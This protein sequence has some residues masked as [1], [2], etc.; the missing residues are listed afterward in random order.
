MIDRKT[1]ILLKKYLTQY[2]VI[3]ITGP[4][5]S[6]KTTLCKAILSDW[7]YINMEDI[8]TRER[9]KAEPKEFLKEYPE[10][11]IID[12]FQ[13]FPE[14]TSY[15]QVIVDEKAKNGLFVLTGSQNFSSMEYISQSLAGRTAII[16]LLPFSIEEI[17]PLIDNKPLNEIILRGFYPKIYNEDINWTEYY[18]FYVNTYIER[19]VRNLVN[20]K[21]LL[22]FEKFLALCAGRS[23][24]ELNISSIATDVGVSSNTIRDWLSVLE[25]CFII[26]LIKPYF[27]NFNKRVV[28]S[29]KLYFIDTGLLSY[30]LDIQNST[31][32]MNHPL[33]GAIF[34]TLI[35]SEIEKFFK[36]NLPTK[37]IYFYRENNG[38]EVDFLIQN[39]DKLIAIEA[40]S[41][42]IITDEILKNLNKIKTFA[43]VEK[44]I[45]IYSG[46]YSY[47]YKNTRIVSYK[48]IAPE[49]KKIFNP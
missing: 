30:L 20:I 42:E 38:C 18:S 34:E 1:E 22:R 43:P 27:N 25:T 28:K 39:G 5:Q 6:G 19:D 16:N 37:Q 47:N 10:G 15:I 11:L 36:N 26:K 29:P 8:P 45:L 40:K 33:R 31:Q 32:L 35:F 17:K 12:E 4:R 7:H 21:D 48:E 2:P 44:S 14:I 23:G 9:V 24:Q 41:T 49:L 3:T 13:R 46:E